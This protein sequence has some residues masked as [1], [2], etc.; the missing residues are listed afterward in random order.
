MTYC[1]NPSKLIHAPDS[2]TQ[3]RSLPHR[4]KPDPKLKNGWK[5]VEEVA[6]SPTALALPV[7][8]LLMAAA[9]QKSLP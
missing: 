7:A 6:H 3:R 4:S 9:Q 1:N 8:Q 2:V 5:M